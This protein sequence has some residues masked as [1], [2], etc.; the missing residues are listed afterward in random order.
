MA[1]WS[2]ITLG[3]EDRTATNQVVIDQ[4]SERVL[5]RVVLE[6]AVLD[7]VVVAVVAFAEEVPGMAGQIG[8]VLGKVAGPE[9][10]DQISGGFREVEALVVRAHGRVVLAVEVQI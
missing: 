9:G 6:M 4:A 3:G 7:W 5:G 2:E 10:V 1:A 8:A